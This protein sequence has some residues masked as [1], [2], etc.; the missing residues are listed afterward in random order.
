MNL[1]TLIPQ[2]EPF[3]FV[4][5]IIQLEPGVRAL[6]K[7]ELRDDEGY[8]K[9]H[10]PDKPV[11]PGVLMIEAAGQLANAV[12]RAL[13][14]HKDSYLYYSK[15]SKVKFMKEAVPGDVLE[16]EVQVTDT[17]EELV[18]CKVFVR[19]DSEEAFRADVVFN[20]IRSSK[21]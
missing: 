4:D 2:K 16:L 17:F 3:L 8:F 1:E 18:F 5:E 12:V 13:P 14:E 15:M 9:G 21:R 11:F 10:F 6:G 20:I 7:K 19:K